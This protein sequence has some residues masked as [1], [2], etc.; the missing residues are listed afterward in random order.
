MLVRIYNPGLNFARICNPQLAV[1]SG[2]Q[3]RQTQSPD[4]KSGLTLSRGFEFLKVVILSNSEESYTLAYRLYKI[5]RCR[6]E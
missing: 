6:S 5:L 1:V 4:Y 2:L 3:I